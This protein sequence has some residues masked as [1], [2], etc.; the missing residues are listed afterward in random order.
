MANTA[1][2]PW[3]QSLLDAGFS[4]NH[5]IDFNTDTVKLAFLNSSYVFSAAH[6]YW[7]DASANEIGTAVAISTVTVTDGT[8][9]AADTTQTSVAGGSTI[10]AYVFYKDTGTATTSALAVFFDADSGG[11]ISVATNGGDVTVQHNASGILSF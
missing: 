1:Y 4:A 10:V 5:P 6:D 11:A 9:D 8:L 7:N 3:L 2:N